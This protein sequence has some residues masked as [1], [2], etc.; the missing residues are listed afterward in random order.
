M[1]AVASAF[2]W[3]SSASSRVR[4]AARVAAAWDER[5][6]VA[7]HRGRVAVGRVLAEF[8][9]LAVLHDRDRLA[10]ELAGGDPFHRCCER[11]EVLEQRAVALRER[12]ERLRVESERAQPLGDHPVV[13]RLVP[14]LPREGQLD[15]DV[16]GGHQPARRDLGGLDLVPERDLEEIEHG[17]VALDLGLQG[18]VGGEPAQTLPVLAVELGDEL[19][20]GHAVTPSFSRR[21]SSWVS[22][23][24]VTTRSQRACQG[25]VCRPSAWVV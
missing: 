17:Q 15:V 9:E 14:D 19:L 18:V 6:H 20:S 11:V 13:L 12:I 16:V 23:S 2:L 5:Y 25:W 7:I 21:G 8:D 22:V 3:S 1:P 24:F 10:G 4:R